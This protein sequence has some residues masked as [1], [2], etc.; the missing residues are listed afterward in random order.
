MPT[1]E[2]LAASLPDPKRDKMPPPVTIRQEDASRAKQDKAFMDSLLDPK[3]DT[4]ER[5]KYAL[6]SLFKMNL[7]KDGDW[8]TYPSGRSVWQRKISDYVGS[9]PAA[10]YNIH[11]YVEVKG[12]SPGNNFN[13]ARIDRS[14]GGKPTQLQKLSVAHN[15][16][17]F[18]MLAIGW[19]VPVPYTQPVKVMQKSR[20]VTRWRKDDVELE[21][22]LIEW[23]DF[24]SVYSS[25]N[26]RSIRRSDMDLFPPCRIYKDG[27]RWKVAEGHW[28]E[29]L[30]LLESPMF[31]IRLSTS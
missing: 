4:E 13:L 10:G 21:I 15:D 6:G 14:E 12:V 9:T 7:K 20:E 25:L 16:G 5:V 29:G 28:W 26:R 22:D 23:N 1:I 19:W 31:G 3:V 30:R 2:E 27:N 11:T 24:L 8:K 18:V 17:N